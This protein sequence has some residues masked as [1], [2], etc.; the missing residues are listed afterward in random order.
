MTAWPDS[1][2]NGNA[3]SQANA[4]ARQTQR[5]G[6]W[7]YSN[8][9]TVDSL[10][11]KATHFPA[12]GAAL[13]GF[14]FGINA[15]TI[16]PNTA[17]CQLLTIS[18]AADTHQVQV[19]SDNAGGIKVHLR[20]GGSN[21][22]LTYAGI[23]FAP[24]SLVARYNGATWEAW[25]N[26]SHQSTA[27]V[28]G[29]VDLDSR[30]VVGAYD[31]TG[32]TVPWNGRVGEYADY[33]AALSDGD[34]STLQGYFVSIT[35]AIGA[36]VYQVGSIYTP[37]AGTVQLPAATRTPTGRIIVT[38]QTTPVTVE[39][40]PVTIQQIHSDDAGATWS[41]PT[42]R[43]SS[44]GVVSAANPQV[45]NGPIGCYGTRVVRFNEWYAGNETQTS[46]TVYTSD[47]DGATWGFSSDLAGI[48]GAHGIFINPATRVVL[49]PD[50]F[51][52]I[53]IYADD[54]AQVNGFCVSAGGQVWA[55][56]AN[57]YS[58]A[59]TWT[60]P[61]VEYIQPFGLLAA[62]YDTTT[63]EVRFSRSQDLGL[64]WAAPSLASGLPALGSGS[65]LSLWWDGA[66]LW[67]GRR[68]SAQLYASW[69]Y[70]ATW[71][72][73]GYAPQ[74]VVLNA[75]YSVLAQLA[76]TGRMWLTDP[77]NTSIART[78]EPLGAWT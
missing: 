67:L 31:T 58:G 70:G 51:I 36:S 78:Q 61:C 20:K 14:T 77:N 57:I 49:M 75:S 62:L 10:G 66:L 15:R 56:R 46:V 21:A 73:A 59:S 29:T 13:A 63:N 28:F 42:A 71:F 1:S 74:G 4:G 76:A 40:N 52:G 69:D 53:P 39:T 54:T 8:V 44:A 24:F 6:R 50:G 3:G 9:N 25:L 35:P 12:P 65:F 23:G 60:E 30:L 41:G 32:A 2:G 33:A 48:L 16:S 55:L 19:Y 43:E 18:N 26:G 68:G 5:V 38:C 7:I 11:A 45:Y 64:T 27:A 37:G 47:D 22:I 34:A 72:S 17:D